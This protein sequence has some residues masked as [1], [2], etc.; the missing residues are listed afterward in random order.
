MHAS[1]VERI[2]VARLEAND[3]D[4]NKAADILAEALLDESGEG[5]KRTSPFTGRVN[6]IATGAGVVE[7]DVD[8]IIK[9]N[10]ANFINNM[11][12]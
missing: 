12:I 9:M 11:V 1:G 2:T 4:E 7:Q 5:L 10:K 8:R 6:L 3:I